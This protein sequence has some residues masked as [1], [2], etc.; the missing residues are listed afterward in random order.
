MRL[1][2]SPTTVGSIELKNRVVM[3]PMTRSRALNNIPN[4]LMASYYAQRAGAGLLITEGTSPSPNGLGYA[5]IPGI[6]SKEQV[7]GWKKVT[8][9]VHDRGGKIVVQLMHTGRVGHP[10]NLPAG[11]ELLA[12]S[13]VKM[14]STKMYSDKEGLQ[15]IPLAKAMSVQDIHQAIAEFVQSAKNAME[16]GF[17]GVELHGANGYLIKQFLNPHSNRRTDEYGGSIENRSRFLLEVVQG[18]AHAIGKEKVGI[19]LSPFGISNETPVYSD[20][21]PLYD[22]VS[23]ELQGIGIAYIHLVDHSSMNGQP[24]PSQIFEIIRKNFKNTLILSGAYTAERAELAIEE[25]RADLIAFGRPYLANPDLVERLK[26]NL[27]LN[28]PNPALFYTTGP[29]GYLDYPVYQQET[30][31]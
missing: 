4:E 26:N 24:V 15:E 28:P 18:V 31:S 20:A 3:A 23:S 7:E 22:Y 11:A 29:E 14:E 27:P 13:A 30:V 1:L 9:A 25:K 6:Y 10:A 21:I 17:D 12:P 8:H 2:F 19:R 5:R 16:A